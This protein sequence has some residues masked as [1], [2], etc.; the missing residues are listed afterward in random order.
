MRVRLALSLQVLMP[1]LDQDTRHTRCSSHHAAYSAVAGRKVP[2]RLGLGA[3]IGTTLAMIPGDPAG[4]VWRGPWAGVWYL[5]HGH[6]DLGARPC[7]V[8]CALASAGV[9]THSLS[10]ADGLTPGAILPV[11]RGG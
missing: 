5:F 6:A 11:D 3:V 4:W 7:P 8:W 1:S 10:P 9:R 2:V